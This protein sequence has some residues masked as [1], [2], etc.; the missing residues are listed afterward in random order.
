MKSSWPIY[1]Q[2]FLSGVKNK[3][4]LFNTFIDNPSF[5]H[6]KYFI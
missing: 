3:V 5:T 4:K 1:D 6:S 2:L